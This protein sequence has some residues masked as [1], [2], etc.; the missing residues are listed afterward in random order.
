MIFNKNIINPSKQY[1]ATVSINDFSGGINSVVD[2]IGVNTKYCTRSFNFNWESKVLKDGFGIKEYKPTGKSLVYPNGTTLRGLYYF[3]RYDSQNEAYA[4]ELLGYF[5]NKKVYAYK[6]GSE[7]T[8]FKEINGMTFDTKPVGINYKYNG[9]NVI[10]LSAEN[11]TPVM[12]DGESVETITDAPQIKSMCIHYERL[13]VAAGGE[14][15]TLWFSDDFDPTNWYVS[16]NEAGY[17][18]FQDDRGQLL[19]VLSFQDYVYIFRTSGISKLQAYGNQEDFE[20]T[21][22]YTT[23]G[24]I[25]PQSITVCGDRIIFLAEDGFYE[26][27]GLTANRILVNYDGL[28]AGIDNSEAVGEFYNGNLYMNL[29]VF[30]CGVITNVTL[31]YKLHFGTSYLYRGP[32]INGMCKIISEREN[33]LLIVCGN[34]GKIGTLTNTGM[35]LGQALEKVWESPKSDFGLSDGRKVLSKTSL[36]VFG[37]V[38]VTI[39]SDEESKSFNLDGNGRATIRTSVKGDVFKVVLHTKDVNVKISRLKLFFRYFGGK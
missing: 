2:E 14:G 1:E 20:V 31:V 6:I 4:D 12:Y 5:D 37:N 21:Q 38:T 28:L 27:N 25:Y 11:K 24:K 18:D 29:K 36:D 34:N 23:S 13:Y 32:K 35:C 19:K 9:K 22:L 15:T 39:E 16:L 8:T 3:K 33:N 17:I 7:D 10:I 30:D 26:F